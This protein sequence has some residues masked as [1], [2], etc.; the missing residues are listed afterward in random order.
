MENYGLASHNHPM[1]WAHWL[2]PNSFVLSP[3]A[4]SYRERTLRHVGEFMQ[5]GFTSLFW[6]QPI[7]P[8]L[9][10]GRL[11]E[12]KKPEDTC[13]ANFSL[14]KDVRRRLHEH[15]P[16][17]FVMGEFCDVFGAQ[18]IDM[19]MSWYCDFEQAVRTAYAFPQTM[20]SWVVDNDPAAASR[21]FAAGM[22]L[23]LCTRGMEGT[24]DDV[25]EFAAH[26]AKLAALRKKC[27]ARTVHA[28]FNH[29]RGITVQGDDHMVAYSYDGSQGPAVIIAAP[30]AA[31]RITVTVERKA[32][33]NPG[34]G[35]TGVI[36]RLDGSSQ[37]LPDDCG[38]LELQ[39][40]EVVVWEL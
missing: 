7:E 6:D 31:G 10:Y 25:P 27:A 30:G 19:W 13:A 18:Y 23:C 3:F 33:A 12:G 36:H 29:T 22:Y 24:L 17:A 35:N 1:F 5:L 26:V 8:N 11:P 40:N 21:A 38:S 37:P 32:F 15:R 9:D 16:D 4:D 20:T 2:G 14:I 28:R 34:T 39:E